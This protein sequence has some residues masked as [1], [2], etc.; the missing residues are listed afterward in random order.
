M[1][2]STILLSPG[3][4]G[5]RN[6]GAYAYF[7]HL[8]AGI[9]RRFDDAGREAS[10]HVADVL[11]TASIRRRASRLA[12][13]VVEHAGGD[14]PIH[15]LGHST[16]GLDARLVASPSVD[17]SGERK[18]LDFATRV[19]SVTTMSSPHYG[20]PLASFFATLAGQ[21]LLGALS[22]LTV[23][24]LKLGSPPLALTSALVAAFAALDRAVGLRLRVVEGLTE[25]AIDLLDSASGSELRALLRAVHEDQGAV[26]QL[27]PEAM[28]LFQAGV[29]DRPGV[30]YQCV[31]SYAPAPGLGQLARALREPWANLSA[32]VF[33]MMQRLASLES[34][35]YR[36]EPPLGAA[37]APL[38][39][40]LGA[41]PPRG[42]NDGVV[43]I[44]SQLWGKVAW[45]GLA[46]HLDVVGHFRDDAAEPRHVDWMSS[47]A[48]FGR[49]RFDAML[50]AVVGGMLEA[51]R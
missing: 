13:A 18:P 10:V 25:R 38:A 43:P 7:G 5:F 39:R 29:E 19:R 11:P 36:C 28:D 50:D 42:A 4:F 24:V 37:E 23:T 34:D 40:W 49:G 47:G 12:Q 8:D 33:S 30:S 6:I 9:A 45:A 35:E 22:A 27:T 2:P 21:R 48:G 20:T 15:L 3:F 14:G 1:A 31:M 32:P 16:G 44:R 26:L 17:L 51:E 41:P 46:D